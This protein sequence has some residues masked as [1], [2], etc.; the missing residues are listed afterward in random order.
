MPLPDTPQFEALL[1]SFSSGK[2]EGTALG[3]REFTAIPAEFVNEDGRWAELPPVSF[4]YRESNDLN[5][6]AF[7]KKVATELTAREHPANL[8]LA[9]VIAAFFALMQRPQGSAVTQFNSILSELVEADLTQHYLFNVPADTPTFAHVFAG[10]IG[11]FRLGPFDPSRL[12]YQSNKAGS[13]YFQRYEKTLRRIPCSVERRHRRVKILAWPHSGISSSWQFG[14]KVAGMLGRV[15]DIYFATLSNLHFEEFFDELEM[16]QELPRA[17]GS[18][19]IELRV[20]R[21]IL[22]AH[23]ISIYLN[24]GGANAG[25]VSPSSIGRMELN[26]GGAHVGVPTT[27]TFLKS[28]YGFES[29]SNYEIHQSLKSFCHFVSLAE[30]HDLAGRNS[31]AF[32]HCVIALD[33]LLGDIGASTA[34]VSSRGA[35]LTHGVLKKKLRRDR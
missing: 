4:W 35:L 22:G 10:D 9:S 28:T 17:L 20:L 1:N 18:G 3:W 6:G 5:L 19:W 27:L 29:F 24:I 15:V 25:F 2:P 8:R 32:L 7:L 30:S 14:P 21:Q 23:Q 12:E 13:D 16:V 31:E 34:A 26:L 33:L 11:P